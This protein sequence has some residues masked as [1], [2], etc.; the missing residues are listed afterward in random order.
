MEDP[1]STNDLVSIDTGGP[2]LD[3]IVFDV[4]SHNKVVVAVVDPVRGPVLRTVSPDELRERT[5][6]GAQDK[7]L[8]LLMR[9]TPAPTHGKSRGAKG[10]GH[11]RSGFSRPTSH[12][13]VGDS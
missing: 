4:P 10:G 9:R 8:Q 13:K 11:G 6:A 12:R 1:L 7:A 3:A 5:D 2:L